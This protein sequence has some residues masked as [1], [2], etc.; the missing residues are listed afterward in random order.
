MSSTEQKDSATPSRK[1][2]AADSSHTQTADEQIGQSF[3]DSIMS[4]DQLGEEQQPARNL[5]QSKIDAKQAAAQDAEE[6]RQERETY[7]KTIRMIMKGLID[8]ME[9]IRKPADKRS[10]EQ[11]MHL[12]CFLAYKVDF[13]KTDEF[14]DSEHMY[15]VAEKVEARVYKQ[16]DVIIR[17][18]EVGDRLYVSVQGVLGLYLNDSPKDLKKDPAALIKE[19]AV[20]GEKSLKYPKEK[21]NATVVCMDHHE[22]VCITMA[23][24]DFKKLINRQTLIAARKRFQFLSKHV[25]ELFD[26]WSRAKIMELNETFVHS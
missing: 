23:R 3:V 1:H 16:N 11:N 15:N 8:I 12:A 2:P 7:I 18:G 6:R 20:V 9:I 24:H 21:R 19:F 17:K 5:Q 25:P 22:T 13:F 10:R 4:E 14:F 26:S